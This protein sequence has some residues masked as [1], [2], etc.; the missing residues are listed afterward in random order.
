[1]IVGQHLRSLELIFSTV[2]KVELKPI[3]AQ[4]IQPLPPALPSGIS[5]CCQALL[6]VIKQQ[7]A[8]LVLKRTRNRRASSA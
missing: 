8:G 1:M 4:K 5:F 6:Q 7:N 2:N 3:L